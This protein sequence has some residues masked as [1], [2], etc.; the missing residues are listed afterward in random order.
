MAARDDSAFRSLCEM[1]LPRRC[2]YSSS[3]KFRTGEAWSPVSLRSSLH[4]LHADDVCGL[5]DVKLAT[6]FLEGLLPEVS[7]PLVLFFGKVDAALDAS[8][9][10]SNQVCL[11]C[12][13]D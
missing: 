8:K 13:C 7:R 6:R 3:S 10:L 1:S 12:P 9:Q 5:Q 2:A 4:C 11:G